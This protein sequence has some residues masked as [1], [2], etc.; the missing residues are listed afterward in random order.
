MKKRLKTLEAKTAQDGL[1]FTVDQV[2]ALEK[3]KADK[4]AHERLT[5]VRPGSSRHSPR[6]RC[7]AGESERLVGTSLLIL[8]AMRH[9]GTL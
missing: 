1:V 5:A 9:P 4:Q 8:P 7:F 2:A 3:A 6:A